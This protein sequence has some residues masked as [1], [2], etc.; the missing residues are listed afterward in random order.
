MERDAAA[1]AARIAAEL[2]R[3]ACGPAAEAMRRR[4]ADYRVIYGVQLPLVEAVAARYAGLPGACEA[5]AELARRPERESRLAALMLAVPETAAGG[6]WDEWIC[7]PETAEAFARYVLGRL[8]GWEDAALAAAEGA[9]G[10]LHV[11]AAL[12][13]AARA[14]MEGR[15]MDAERWKAAAERASAEG[16]LAARAA[17]TLAENL[18][19]AEGNG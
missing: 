9:A 2:G 3:L 6:D 5:A 7:G 8:P 19:W 10:P 13:A 17:E 15:S 16:G 14:A 1:L 12:L 18:D 11:Y 4:G